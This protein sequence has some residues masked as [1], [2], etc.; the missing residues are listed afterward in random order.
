MM[1]LATGVFLAALLTGAAHAQTNA[2]EQKTDPGLPF[3]MTKVASFD[4]PWRI[5]FLPDG[6]MLVTEKVGRV[7]LVTPLGAKTEIAG[8]P[9]SYVEGQNGMLGVFLSPHYATD[10]SVYLTYV[11]P[12]DY[13]GGLTLGRGRLVLDDGKQPRLD[14]FKVLWRQMP[15]G[16]GGQAGAQ[17]AF[18]PD[19]KYLF[20]TVGDRQRFTPAQDP[21]QPEGKILRL[22]L[23]GKPAPGNPWAGKVG[24]RTIP[25]IDPAEDTEKAKTA[26]VVSTYTFPGPNLTPAETWATGFR[27]PYGLAFAPDGRLWE[28]EHGPRGGDELNLIQRGKNYGW[29]LVSYGV[30]YNGVSIPS[31]DTRPD[32]AKPVIYW[33]PVIAPGNLMFYKG[34]AFPQWNGSALIGGLASEAIVRVTFDGK[35]GAKAVQ[36]WDIGKRVR[37]IEEAP[38]GSLWMLED[39]APGGL[40]HLMPK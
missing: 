14:G 38:D 26:P 13:G 37:D 6:R 29:P 23:D 18:S 30:N 36:R 5:A 40:Y 12:G 9:P 1:K 11:A 39:A 20:L 2:G 3:T 32:L 21:N 31:P 10:H 34:S 15:S 24:A 8:V 22:T 28:L 17:I 33:V 35:G 25:L 7:D 19:G 4:L 27:T 16:K